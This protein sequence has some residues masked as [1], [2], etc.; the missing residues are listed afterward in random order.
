M[1]TQTNG[2]SVRLPDGRELS[3]SDYERRLALLSKDF[4]ASQVE[5][6][7]KP[8]KGG[9]DQPRFQCRPGTQASA[10]GYHC[11]GY[12]SRAIHLDY[13]GHATITER[14]NEVDPFWTIDFMVK[15]PDTGQPQVDADGTW[16]V[17]TVLGVSRP[18]IGDAG[19]KGLTA[20]GR[21]EL[22]G[23]A[24]RNGAM[25]FGV[26]TYLWS[27]SE[28]AER[29]KLGEAEATQGTAPADP[30]APQQAPQQAPAERPAPQSSPWETHLHG[31]IQSGPKAVLAFG[32]WAAA[33]GAP[34]DIID[35]AR[36]ALNQTQENQS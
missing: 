18:C 29:R 20:N 9:R 12:H 7:P 2:E 22:M 6:L 3:Q 16:F 25:R 21:K 1:T 14:L 17:M 15:Q 36:Q 26:G 35:R 11:G 34:Q 31:A 13:I 30:P 28:E 5:K 24:I 19:G 8:L 23:D 4:P 32:K 33:N 27:K 10:D